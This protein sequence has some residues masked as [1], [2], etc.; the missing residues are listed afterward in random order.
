MLSRRD[1]ERRYG[2]KEAE[3]ALELMRKYVE[4]VNKDVISVRET[5]RQFSEELVRS[6][7]TPT[8]AQWHKDIRKSQKSIEMFNDRRRDYLI[9]LILGF[10]T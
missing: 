10:P 9:T 4:Q 1:F 6:S 5:V 8:M 3:L 7:Q 2:K